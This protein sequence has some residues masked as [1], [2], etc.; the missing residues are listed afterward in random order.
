MMDI[1][2]LHFLEAKQQCIDAEGN[3]LFNCVKKSPE[4]NKQNQ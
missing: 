4:L 2:I 3:F 1:F